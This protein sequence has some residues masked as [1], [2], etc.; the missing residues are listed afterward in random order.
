MTVSVSAPSASSCLKLTSFDMDRGDLEGASILASLQ[1]STESSYQGPSGLLREISTSSVRST[2]DLM[3]AKPFMLTSLSAPKASEMGGSAEAFLCFTGGSQDGI[4][5]ARAGSTGLATHQ[6]GMSFEGEDQAT[7]LP[8]FRSRG[9]GSFRS[10]GRSTSGLFRSSLSEGLPLGLLPPSASIAAS[11]SGSC[12]GA[13]APF[14]WNC[15]SVS[16]DNFLH[17]VANASVP[18][19]AASTSSAFNVKPD[20]KVRAEDQ[21]EGREEASAAKAEE[22]P[23]PEAPAQRPQRAA[24]A[25]AVSR[26]QEEEEE[27]EEEDSEDDHPKRK[28]SS[29]KRKAGAAAGG[30]SRKRAR[31]EEAGRSGLHVRERPDMQKKARDGQEHWL[32]QVKAIRKMWTDRREWEAQERYQA[33]VETCAAMQ[34]KSQHE[35]LLRTLQMSA[36][37]GLIVPLP[38]RDCGPESF[39]GW[40]GFRVVMDK[41]QEF[42]SRIDALFPAP[43]KENTLHTS[44]RRAGLVPDKWSSGWLGLT[45]FKYSNDKR[46]AYAPTPAAAAA[47]RGGA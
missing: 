3:S 25:R 17:V 31:A 8:S 39:L 30:K 44:F 6:V 27:D 24:A 23:E 33:Q 19:S 42:R 9:A 37:D 36:T 2:D 35:C 21:G 7:A 28:G 5:S 15:H 11:R 16:T 34:I 40:T 22:E 41:A 10:L 43:L 14:L 29:G 12:D 1:G 20:Y 32:C 38:F 13:R 47:A 46:V 18:P 26:V 45:A 4:S